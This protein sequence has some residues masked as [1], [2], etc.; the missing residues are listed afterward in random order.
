MLYGVALRFAAQA[1]AEQRAQLNESWSYEAG[2]A[3]HIDARVIEAR[4]QAIGLWRE[5]GRADK[6][7]HTTC[8]GCHAC[9]GTAATRLWPSA[10]LTRPLPCCSRCRRGPSWPGIEHALAAVHAAG[11]HGPRR[12]MG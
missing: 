10:S 9:I 3:L 5:A 12:R 7:G 11:P 2:L 4:H 6:V 8:A 1:P